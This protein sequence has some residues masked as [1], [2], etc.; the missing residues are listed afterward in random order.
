[1]ME[2]LFDYDKRHGW[3]NPSHLAYLFNDT[4][5]KSLENLD[6]NFLIKEKYFDEIDLDTNDI[7]NQ[8]S[9]TFNTFPYFKNHKTALVIK[10]E[11]N[12]F[13]SID[14]NFEM[15][16]VNWS[17]EYSWARSQISIDELGPRPE[18][19][20][21]ILNFGDLVYLKNNIDFKFMFSNDVG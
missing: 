5:K 20:K 19:F 4:Q 18:D 3:R 11:R 21:D 6:L 9:S 1:M 14:Q 15:I 8:I 7:S 17:N 16:E 12:R 2:Q 13:F 10:V